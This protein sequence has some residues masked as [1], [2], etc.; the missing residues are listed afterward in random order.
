MTRRVT[1]GILGVALLAAAG[2]L[3]WRWYAAPEPPPLPVD[4][5]EPAVA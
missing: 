1:L 5:M 3:G 2:G 4:R